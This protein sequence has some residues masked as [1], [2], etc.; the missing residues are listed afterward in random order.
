MRTFEYTGYTQEGQGARGLIE[1]LDLKEAR[2]KLARQGVLARQVNPAGQHAFRKGFRRRAAFGTEIRAT[3]YREL[4]AILR[5]G[6]PLSGALALLIE[7]PELGE[8]RTRLA[9]LRDR[10]RDGESFAEALAA[11]SPQVTSFEKAAIETGER[12]G[13]LET[14]LESMAL[15][16][17][18]RH[19]L[20]ERFL[21]ALIYPAV[22]LVLSLIIGV[23]ML[24][25]MLPA[26]QNLLAEAQLDV[27][28][29]TRIT[30]GFGRVVMVLAV[31]LAFLVPVGVIGCVRRM[32]S[33]PDFRVM[34][35]RQMF[36]LPV[37]GRAYAALSGL[38]FARTLAILLRSGV[39]LLE[40]LRMAGRATGSPWIDTLIKQE[41][42]RVRQGGSLPDSVAR[43]PPLSMSLPGW[44]RAGEASGDL[45]GMLENAGIRFQRQWEHMLSRLMATMEP[46]LIVLVGLFVLL[47]AVSILLPIMS[48][49]RM[50]Y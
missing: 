24:A 7:S 4:G 22:I 6:I 32:R 46:V 29:I 8:N 30:M 1:A 49:N 17:E 2:E 31:L 39:P 40:G 10:V 16:L 19:R 5:A 35:D 43:V 11:A 45:A 12:A 27:P 20:R 28:L 37:A 3:L 25:Y 26:F 33:D 50:L 23:L 14:V 48:L 47:L 38:R 41:A 9:G 34:V 42:E 13:T 15:Y 36:R 18:D 44:I 21:T